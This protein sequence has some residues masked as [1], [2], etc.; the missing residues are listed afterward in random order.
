M[1]ARKRGKDSSAQSSG[2][3]PKRAP[4]PQKH[5][6]A[7]IPGA[8]GGAQPGAGRPPSIVRDALRESGDARRWVL[9]EIADGECVQKAKF[10]VGL[11][12][13][14]VKCAA[15]GVESQIRAKNPEDALLI[16][17]EG[18]VSATPNERTKAVDTLFK[19]GLTA[20]MP[21]D[22]VR[23]KVK[24][25]LELAQGFMAPDAFP[26]FVQDAKGIWS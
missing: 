26:R 24:A 9:E 18:K 5:G 20:G 21:M 8:G 2:A 3:K 13:P 19:Y 22:E 1:A 14:H 16:S 4:I 17:I 15:C 10:P 11:L 25:T 23:A 6:G 12:A 7:L